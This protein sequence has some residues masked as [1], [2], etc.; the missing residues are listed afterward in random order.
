MRRKVCRVT[1]TTGLGS[2][3]AGFISTISGI[4]DTKIL[5]NDIVHQERTRWERY[6]SAAFI[7]VLPSN[8]ITRR[9]TDANQPR[10]RSEMFR[11]RCQERSLSFAKTIWYCLVLGPTSL[12]CKLEALRGKVRRPTIHLHCTEIV[13]D[14]RWLS[15]KRACLCR[16]PREARRRIEI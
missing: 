5:T 3:V 9:R 1:F 10:L 13:T 4:C 7:G 12:V 15:V 2:L 11:V 8:R 14:L 6:R 16:R